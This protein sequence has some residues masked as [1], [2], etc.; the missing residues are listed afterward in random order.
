MGRHT[1]Y[2][3]PADLAVTCALGHLSKVSHIR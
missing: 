2:S 1:H 3:D